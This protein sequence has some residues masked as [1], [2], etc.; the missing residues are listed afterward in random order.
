MIRQI[1]HEQWLKHKNK[2]LYFW[3]KHNFPPLHHMVEWNYAEQ[4]KETA[5]DNLYYIYYKCKYNCHWKLSDATNNN[6]EKAK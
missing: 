3:N 6:R 1:K 5:G 4:H 2:M